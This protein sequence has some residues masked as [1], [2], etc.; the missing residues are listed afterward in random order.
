MLEIKQIRLSNLPDAS[1]LC[2]SGKDPADRPRAFTPD[3][4]QA[5][6]RKKLG[7]LSR[8]MR[9]GAVA[10]TAY[11]S[12]MLVGYIELHPVKEALAPVGG[13]D[14]YVVQCLR[15]PE[16][17]ERPDT[18]LALIDAAADVWGKSRGLAVVAR[19]KDW[20]LLG[21]EEAERGPDQAIGYERVLWFK[22]GE[23]E[24]DAPQFL[25]MQRDWPSGTKK[26][27]V[28]MF[29]SDRCPWDRYVF[30]LVRG[31]CS[32]MQHQ[33]EIY[34]T[35]TNDRREIERSGISVGIAINGQFLNWLRPYRL[36]SEHE[37]RRAIDNAS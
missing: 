26:V 32:H 21:F 37:I 13:E 30:D 6:M 14:C 15:V 5:C 25:R 18:E 17:L 2:V 10:Y 20:S 7:L 1:R 11:R 19:E 4:E 12:G 35:D 29:V 31:V 3:V 33:V 16:P 8:K 28:E 27:R 34:E 9:G 36:P 22:R 23:K 24:G